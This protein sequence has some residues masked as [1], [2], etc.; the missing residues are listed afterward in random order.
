[1]LVKFRIYKIDGLLMENKEVSRYLWKL[2]LDFILK[3][4]DK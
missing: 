3:G 1:M 4:L 2:K